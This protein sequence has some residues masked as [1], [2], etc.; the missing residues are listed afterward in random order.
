MESAF[1]EAL[2]LFVRWVHVIAA[3][4]WIGDSFLFMWLDSHLETPSKKRE[5][6]VVGELWMTHSGGF[7]EVVKRRYL[8][9]EEMPKN[10]YW[11]KWESYT[12]W[13]S[14]F[15]L[16]FVVY[17]MNGASYLVDPTISSMTTG[18]GILL[19]LGL[20]ASGFIVYDLLWS[21]PLGKRPIILGP[22]C[23]IALVAIAAWLTT[24]YSGRAA[25]LQVGAMMGTIMSANVFFRIIP[26][27]R[28]MLAAARAGTPVDTSLG[29]RAK[30]RSRHNHYMTLPVLFTMLSNHFPAI[31]ASA[32]P[33]LL[34]GIV[35]LFGAGLK[36]LMNYRRQSPA[37]VWLG[38]VGSLV[39]IVI[40]SSGPSVAAHDDGSLDAMKVNSVEVQRIVAARCTT[41][42]ATVPSSAQFKSPPA[43]IV[44]EHPEQIAKLAPRIFERVYV[45]ETMPLGNATGMLPEERRKVAAWIKQGAIITAAPRWEG[46]APPPEL[47][48]EAQAFYAARCSTCHGETGRGDGPAAKG[49]LP[50]PTDLHD[51]NWQAQISDDEL[52]KVLLEGGP[53][54]GKAGTM[55]PSIDL[56]ERPDLHH[57]LVHVV[58]KMEDPAPESAPG[59]PNVA[60][61]PRHP[62]P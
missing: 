43:G 10:L 27:Q 57:A 49:M 59:F 61:A 14:G 6:A 44:L 51:R 4:M 46:V 38:T 7:Y 35:F 29:L 34:L 24:L 1:Q 8:A 50:R 52:K 55:P 15:F 9:R 42:H 45:N 13:L 16:L 19:S 36:Y 5:G 53:A 17:Y 21:S 32:H 31:H 12:T 62:L 11:F 39:A 33:W 20:L 30:T 26:A 48:N 41:C 56:D 40:M 18:T 58:R 23:F 37:I 47:M 28:N 22:L 3:I 25:F 60:P 2:N 54:L